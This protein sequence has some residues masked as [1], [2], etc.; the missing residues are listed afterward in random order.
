MTSQEK[1]V[2][3]E[4]VQ[5]VKKVEKTKGELKP[6]I[7]YLTKNAQ[8]YLC[9]KLFDSQG[10]PTI[11]TWLNHKFINLWKLANELPTEKTYLIQCFYNK[12]ETGDFV[13]INYIKGSLTPFNMTSF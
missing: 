12:N 1:V 2:K 13:F 3:V 8:N 4:K 11:E 9:L 6:L 10:K 7:V 5:D